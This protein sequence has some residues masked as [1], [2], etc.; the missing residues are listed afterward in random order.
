MVGVTLRKLAQTI[1]LLILNYFTQQKFHKPGE[2]LP[3]WWAALSSCPQGYPNCAPNPGSVSS[4]GG[5]LKQLAQLNHLGL[6]QG[7]FVS[8]LLLETQLQLQQYRQ[9]LL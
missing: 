5:S 1:G 7:Y 2:I 3:L 6:Q 9:G 4:S 8:T